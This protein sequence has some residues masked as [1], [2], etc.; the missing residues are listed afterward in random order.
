VSQAA[1]V[2][3]RTCLGAGFQNDAKEVE[4]NEEIVCFEVLDVLF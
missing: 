4:R 2:P 3:Y 1:D